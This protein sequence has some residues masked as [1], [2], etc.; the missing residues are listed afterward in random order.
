M[1]RDF[2]FLPSKKRRKKKKIQNFTLEI[3]KAIP[4][5][6]LSSHLEASQLRATSRHAHHARIRA[7]PHPPYSYAP[8][9]PF[10]KTPQFNQKPRNS[11]TLKFTNSTTD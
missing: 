1:S 8:T 9:P 4:L 3:K 5:A 6:C 7:S 11:K 2:F 10:P